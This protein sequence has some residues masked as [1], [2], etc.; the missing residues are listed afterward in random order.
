MERGV[1]SFA[2]DYMNRSTLLTIN[3]VLIGA[4]AFMGLVSLF[5]LLIRPTNIPVSEAPPLTKPMPPSGFA[6]SAEAYDN[7][8][9]TFLKLDVI[10]PS[11]QLPNLRSKLAYF[12]PM[13]RP[14][15]SGGDT[16]L[17]FGVT[18]TKDQAS[19]AP[20]KNLYILYDR[21]RSPPGYIFSPDNK[22][23]FLWL[24]A[25]PK[26]KSALV[27]V[28]IRN[29]EGEIV[30]S[31]PENAEFTLKE[32]PLTRF[33]SRT[34]WEIGK[35]RVDGTLLARQRAR[36]YG[37]DQF[38]E[39]HGGEEYREIAQKQRI[40][41]GKDPDKY[42]I[43]LAL[44][45][46]AVWNGKRWEVVQPGPDSLGKPLL[47]LKKVEA[48]LVSFDLWNEEGKRRVSLN[49]L[50]S[51]EQWSS[52][53]LEKDFDFISAR[54]RTQY[55]FEIK[56]NRVILR[57]HDWLLKIGKEWQKLTTEKEIDAY[58]NRELIGSLFIFNGMTDTEGGQALT[59]TLYNTSRTESKTIELSQT[60]TTNKAPTPTEAPPEIPLPPPLPPLDLPIDQLEKAP[61]E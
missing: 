5:I 36:W 31:P 23:T 8:D 14:D 33:G 57:P 54:T 30:A 19:I 10:P 24:T 3:S 40:D 12:G 42:S 44:G 11:L 53:R 61:L 51:K 39:Q 21:K 35:W 32:K 4:I 59:A 43:Y 2:L 16:S 9:E 48:R 17:H 6:Q 26:E 60:E 13:G 28:R 46:I 29:H 20:D 37:Q 50:K 22:P 52:K 45:D 25:E 18:K 58:V 47:H 1:V 49:L 38:L 56:K 7:I 27:K 55:I 15:L 41:F 34:K